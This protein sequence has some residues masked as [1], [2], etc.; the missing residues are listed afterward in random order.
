MTLNPSHPL[1]LGPVAYATICAVD[2]KSLIQTWCKTLDHTLEFT[3]PMPSDEANQLG[4]PSIA[5]CECFWLANKC[6]DAWIRVCSVSLATRKQP[7]TRYG[8]LA[9][10]IN[11]VSVDTL[12]EEVKSAKLTVLGTPANLAFS[13]AIRAMQCVT[14]E[15]DVMYLT[16]IMDSV[17]SF[18]LP[19]ARTTVDRVFIPVAL[20]PNRTEALGFYEALCGSTG[21]S[22]DTKITTLSN[23]LGVDPNIQHPVATLQLAGANLIELDEVKDLSLPV[24]SEYPET[25]ILSVSF[26]TSTQ[27]QSMESSRISSGPYE[28]FESTIKRGA[29]GELVEL[30]Y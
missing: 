15:G 24:P 25:G 1:R 29:G 3:V 2:A 26:Q 4:Y 5:G 10:E 18:E 30:I 19:M 13:D 8:W 23:A 27:Q 6:E 20:V 14:P 9:L 12:Y 17:P 21:I 22:F 7:Y 16:Q 28:G 11:V